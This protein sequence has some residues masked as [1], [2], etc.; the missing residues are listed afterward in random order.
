MNL[1]D[2]ATVE[3]GET[4]RQALSFAS[5][6]ATGETLTGTPSVAMQLWPDS[7]V[8]DANAGGLIAGSGSVVG[9]TVVVKCGGS[10]GFQAG[11]VYSLYAACATS[12][13]QTRT[14]FGQITCN[15]IAPPAALTSGGGGGGTPGQLDFSNPK[16]SGLTGLL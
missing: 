2:L 4:I 6:L 9:N 13:G 10:S 1:G 7:P 3:Q 11:A 5:V 12:N 15:A 14:V 8:P 16:N